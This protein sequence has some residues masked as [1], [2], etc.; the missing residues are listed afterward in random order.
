MSDVLSP[1]SPTLRGQVALIT[2]GGRGIGA[3]TAQALAR[4]GAHVVI[5]SRSA[6]ELDATVLQ[7]RAA[8]LA[9]SARVLDVADEAAVDAVFSDIAAT[10]GR[11]DILVN[12]AG[13]MDRFLPVGELTDDVWNR[14]FAVNVN[15][16]MY[17]MRRAIPIMLEQGGGVIVNVS[18]A[19]GLGGGFA[20][21]AYTA[22]K[23][24]VV[25]LTRTAGIE[26][27]KDNIR[28]NVV[29]PGG[30]RTDLLEKVMSD[31][32]VLRDHIVAS[33]PMRRLAEPAE[34]ADAVL[35][36]VSPRS[37]FVNGAVVPVDGGYTA[38]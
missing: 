7:L 18:S 29:C 27:G 3:A 17:T 1:V 28:T 38:G 22:S 21:A 36:L 24:A 8:G 25:G 19:A 33:C 30:T 32:P 37:S 9:A 6:A 15:G 14:V 2:G 4:K 20:G 31:N 13:I 10:L 5:A 16:P 34:I 23:H 26:F 35:W 11:L 12:N